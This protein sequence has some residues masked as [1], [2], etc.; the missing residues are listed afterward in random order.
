MISPQKFL[1]LSHA[2]YLIV[3]KFL[4]EAALKIYNEGLAR[5]EAQW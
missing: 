3:S 4:D 2:C 1:S 5:A